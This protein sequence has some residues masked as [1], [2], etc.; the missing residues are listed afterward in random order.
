MKVMS[1]AVRVPPHRTTTSTIFTPPPTHLLSS[2]LS[3][4]PPKQL[5]AVRTPTPTTLLLHLASDVPRVPAARAADAARPRRALWQV[6]VGR[7]V[8]ER[9][10]QHRLGRDGGCFRESSQAFSFSACPWACVGPHLCS[11]STSGALGRTRTSWSALQCTADTD[12]LTL[13]YPSSP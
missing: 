2:C 11:S 5:H 6:C 10:R 12:I 1:S 9:P 4:H 3:L 8:V 13:T 7:V